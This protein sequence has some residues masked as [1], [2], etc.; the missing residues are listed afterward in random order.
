ML[1]A[2]GQ[3]P[4]PGRGGD[5]GC[6][7]S[8][9]GRLMFLVALGIKIGSKQLRNSSENCLEEVLLPS[10]ALAKSAYLSSSQHSLLQAG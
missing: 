4:L 2:A 6:S 1:R 8:G 10:P 9:W 7:G 5:T 3:L